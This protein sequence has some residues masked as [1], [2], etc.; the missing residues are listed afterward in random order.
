MSELLTIRNNIRNFFRKFD[1]ITIPLIRFVGSLIMFNT[2]KNLF[3][4]SDLFDQGGIIFLLALICSLVPNGVV[5]FLGGI[6]ILLNVASVGT[7]LA[8]AFGVLYIVIF[9]TYMR[10]FPDC[11]WIL[12][13]VPVLYTL[14]LEFATPV[15]V[16]IFAGL[17]GIIPAAFGVLIY[18]FA[19]A[20]KEIHNISTTKENDVNVFSYIVDNVLKNKEILLTILVF[21][22]IIAI[23]YVIYRLNIDY[24]FYIGIAVSGVLSII[25]FPICGAILKVD[26]PGMGSVIIG[27][28]VGIIVGAIAQFFKGIFDY[29]HKESVQFEDDEFY[30]YVK[31]VPKYDVPAKNKVVKKITEEKT[32]N[33]IRNGRNKAEKIGQ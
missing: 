14:H 21:A 3:G 11:S 25:C 10:M 9:C 19:N 6:V 8:L 20:T 17:P 18:Y 28:L 29:A 24:A 33:M 1:E 4:Y 16:V 12:A 23:G 15:I 27:S 5:V 13:L 22:L 30:Y 32:D 7:E 31:A 26:G 2:I